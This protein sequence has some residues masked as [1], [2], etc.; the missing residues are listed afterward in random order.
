MYTYINIH[1][2]VYIFQYVYIHKICTYFGFLYTSTTFH[3]D[4]QFH[5]TS[6]SLYHIIR[7]VLS[8]CFCSLMQIDSFCQ[9]TKPTTE[10]CV[11]VC[12]CVPHIH[13]SFTYIYQSTKSP[14]QRKEE[15]IHANRQNVLPPPS[16]PAPPPVTATAVD[17]LAYT[18]S[19]AH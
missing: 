10:M 16:C 12:V 6:D 14:T 8:S 5:L 15:K 9:T 18:F 1:T 19:C 7:P 17:L 3:L 11:R 2:Y 4:S 13:L